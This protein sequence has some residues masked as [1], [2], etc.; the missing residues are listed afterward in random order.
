MQ[1]F[2]GGSASTYTC[3][4]WRCCRCLGRWRGLTNG[5][6]IAFL[7]RRCFVTFSV[8]LTSFSKNQSVSIFHVLLG[9]C[10]RSLESRYGYNRD[11]GGAFCHTRGNNDADVWRKRCC[12]PRD[13][14][15]AA[16]LKWLR[17]VLLS[18][19]WQRW[20]CYHKHGDDGA[21]VTHEWRRKIHVY[22]W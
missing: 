1:L 10:C 21:A 4:W 7:V 14:D 16:T 15:G 22:T 20:R 11:G 17:R 8:A 9:R 6:A 2:S 5:A 13:S 19:T 12:H 3:Y 18:Q